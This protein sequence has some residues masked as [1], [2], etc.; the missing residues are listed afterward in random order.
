[1]T[2]IQLLV[3]KEDAK[4]YRGIALLDVTYKIMAIFIKERLQKVFEDTMGDYQAGFR[5]E[6]SIRGHIH[7][8]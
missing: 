6:N 3:I 5:K 1:M 8:L 2:N 7:V 4:N